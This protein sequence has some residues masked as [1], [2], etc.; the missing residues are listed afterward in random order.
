MN[1]KDVH[2]TQQS[3]EIII[4]NEQG[5]VD[6]NL[7]SIQNVEGG[8]LFKKVDLKAMPSP[9]RVFGY[10]FYTIAILMLLVAIYVSVFR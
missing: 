5:Y 9:L 7:R 1:K 2:E 10:V 4:P 8:G 6:E 3:S